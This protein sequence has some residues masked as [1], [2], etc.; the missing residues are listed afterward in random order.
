MRR[1]AT[2]ALGLVVG[3][4]GCFPDPPP[5]AGGRCDTADAFDSDEVDGTALETTLPDAFDSSGEEVA[6]SDS[7]DAAETSTSD[8]HS[9]PPDL[10]GGVDAH[11][12]R[13]SGLEDVD[14]TPSEDSDTAETDTV[15]PTCEE[16]DGPCVEGV[17]SAAQSA[18][19]TASR[20]NGSGCDDRDACTND[21]H[22]EDGSCVGTAK[23]CVAASPCHLEGVC[24]AQT[25]LCTEPVAPSTTNCDDD[26]SCTLDD[27]CDEGACVGLPRTDTGDWTLLLPEAFEPYGIVEGTAP[28]SYVVIGALSAPATFGPMADGSYQAFDQTP[29]AYLE[30]VMHGGSMRSVS[31]SWIAR[32][33][34]SGVLSL[35]SHHSFAGEPLGWVATF[36][37]RLQSTPGACANFS[38]QNADEVVGFGKN[39]ELLCSDWV[40]DARSSRST[41]RGFR[42]VVTHTGCISWLDVGP[43]G[44]SAETVRLCPSEGEVAV[45]L[46]YCDFSMLLF[47]EFGLPFVDHRSVF[48]APSKISLPVIADLEQ[49]EDGFATLV[50][51][52][53]GSDF[54]APVMAALPSSAGE[55]DALVMNLDPQGELRWHREIGGS[56]EDEASSVDIGTDLSV[57]VVGI[58]RSSPATI[59]EGARVLATLPIAPSGTG[60]HP[61]IFVVR[62]DYEGNVKWMHRAEFVNGSA[63]PVLGLEVEYDPGRGTRLL[64]RLHQDAPVFFDLGRSR[65]LRARLGV[66]LVEFDAADQLRFATLAIRADDLENAPQSAVDAWLGPW[67]NEAVMLLG[68][69]NTA[70]DAHHVYGASTVSNSLAS[71]AVTLLNSDDALQCSLP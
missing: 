54:T 49:G 43:D 42:A 61:G 55:G 35:R 26:D 18:C 28:G 69:M 10:D 59:R 46:A 56:R 27:H 70:D 34:E 71:T 37:E 9:D 60:T 52:F 44:M 14:G 68:R 2:S 50:A 12:G 30:V 41:E 25:G 22:C 51:T 16:L 38:W 29:T 8:G 57:T 5:C 19:T 32:G 48:E 45:T 6:G 64:T 17:W 67:E 36:R 53:S 63:E 47:S 39:S 21:D 66:G 13:D 40:W 33:D 24:I 11:D 4:L 7:G 62:F 23:I 20:P 15:R 3:M 31:E 1:H 65:A 58:T